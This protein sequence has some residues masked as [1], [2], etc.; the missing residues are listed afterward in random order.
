MRAL[1]AC[2]CALFVSSAFA[3]ATLIPASSALIY[4]NTPPNVIPGTPTDA[5]LL[6]NY[7]ATSYSG[8]TATTDLGWTEHSDGVA[9]VID[10]MPV[11]PGASANGTNT[12]L[13][14]FHPTVARTSISA[15]P[16][17]PSNYE[18][19]G[20]GYGGTQTSSYLTTT[21]G[22]WTMV[23]NN[24]SGQC[25]TSTPFPAFQS[26]TG[27]N[28]SLAT[29]QGKLPMLAA[30]NP[31][32]IEC[33]YTLSQQ[34]ANNWFAEWL[35]TA[36]KNLGS[37]TKWAE[38]DVNETPN[39]LSLGQGSTLHYWGPGNNQLYVASGSTVTYTAEHISGE[40]WNPT[41]ATPHVTFYLDGSTFS[42]STVNFSATSPT[43]TPSAAWSGFHH[44]LTLNMQG[45]ANSV[46][47]SAVNAQVRYCAAFVSP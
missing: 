30:S 43:A 33:G 20:S 41:A 7:P 3:Q 12:L 38:V 26:V 4:F 36:E 13:W 19:F 46:A 18:L 31:Y 5:Y 39:N 8:Y 1:L 24:G 34:N 32:Y 35:W 14:A 10:T 11:P 37:T 45:H 17:L 16:G 25:P 42:G 40:A 29:L 28:T 21:N 15:T 23:C 22:Q 9:W 2:F 44:F 6:A 47:G 27:N